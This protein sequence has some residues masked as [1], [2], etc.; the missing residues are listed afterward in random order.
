MICSVIGFLAA[1]VPAQHPTTALASTQPV[2]GPASET[3][4]QRDERMAWWREA[5]FGMFI[6]WGA[7]AVPADGEWYMTNAKVPVADYE[8]YATQLN[9]V[10]FDADKIA[11]IAEAAGQKYLVITSKHHD[12]FCMFQN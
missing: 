11:A 9:P 8:R 10:K 3:S 1:K 6:H 12:G 7:Y 5:R 4:A 2:T